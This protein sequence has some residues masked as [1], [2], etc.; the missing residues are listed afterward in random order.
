MRFFGQDLFYLLNS[1]RC[2]GKMEFMSRHTLNVTEETYLAVQELRIRRMRELGTSLTVDEVLREL[3][4]PKGTPRPSKK[5]SR[6]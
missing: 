4:A 1:R 2:G 5:A 6:S 3:L